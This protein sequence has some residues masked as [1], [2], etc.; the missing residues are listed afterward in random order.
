MVLTVFANCFCCVCTSGTNCV[1]TSGTNCVCTSGTNCVC[2]IGTNCFCCVCCGGGTISLVIALVSEGTFPAIR[3][4]CRPSDKHRPCDKQI[5]GSAAACVLLLGEL[6]CHALLGPAGMGRSWLA[7]RVS[8]GPLA[9]P[10]PSLHLRPRRKRFC[11]ATHNSGQSL[12]RTRCR[13]LTVL[14]QLYSLVATFLSS[15]LER[16]HDLSQELLSVFRQGQ[17]PVGQD[18]K[19]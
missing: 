17:R 7:V 16:P 6:T 14:T 4:G 2:T 15:A 9:E 18:D 1:C 12:R 8:D 19:L 3:C 10:P 11:N 5:G 13:S